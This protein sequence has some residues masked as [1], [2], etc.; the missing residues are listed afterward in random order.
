ME[1]LKVWN[2]WSKLRET[3]CSMIPP[4]WHLSV[5]EFRA[6]TFILQQW[7]NCY[8]L[9]LGWKFSYTFHT[10][11][12]T[13]FLITYIYM[14]LRPLCVCIANC[15]FISVSKY[16]LNSIKLGPK[17]P[18]YNTSENF[19]IKYVWFLLYFYFPFFEVSKIIFMR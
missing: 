1:K 12:A 10:S 9:W 19:F 11:W 6:W 4:N 8:F 13:K 5:L 15:V 18:Q 3:Y 2:S 14:I 17:I 7:T 16:L